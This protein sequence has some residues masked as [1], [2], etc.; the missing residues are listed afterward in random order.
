MI[1][2]QPIREMLEKEMK[3]Y[4]GRSKLNLADVDSVNK[5]T[6]SIKNTLKIELL[7]EELA[8]A[9]SEAR[10]SR[11]GGYAY[12]D[13]GNSYARRGRHYVRG[14]YSRDGGMYSQD[15]YSRDGNT[16]RAVE[17]LRDMMEDASPEEQKTIE[18]MLQAA[19]K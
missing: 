15:G 19:R 3:Q 2:Y 16:D 14:H 4:E 12:D 11:R 13:G 1:D 8:N 17:I 5:L 9:Y 10:Y 7:I 18:R 6:D